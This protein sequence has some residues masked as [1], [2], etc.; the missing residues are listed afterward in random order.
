VAA[1]FGAGTRHVF[2]RLRA[3]V[4][5]ARPRDLVRAIVRTYDDNDLLTYAS[6]ISFQV[7]FALIPLLLFA[8]GL[9]GFLSLQELWRSDIA[10]EIQSRV[11]AAAFQ[12][13]S[14]TV[15]QVLGAKHLFWVTFGAVIAVWEISGAVRAVM[16][17]FNRIYGIDETRS[18]WRR[19]RVSLTLAAVS[20]VLLLLA[21]AVVRFGGLAVDALGAGGFVVDLAGFV[22]RWAV[23][24]ALMLVVVG[25]MV[26][27][28][29]NARRA[30][31]WVSF[32]ALLVVVGWAAMTAGFWWYVSNV[33]E[34]ESIFGS[35]ATVIVVMTYL[36]WS[37]IVFL[38]GVQLDALVEEGLREG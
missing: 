14:S 23:A 20:G 1:G 24:A 19:M 30:L 34:Y 10:P 5:C 9:L 22:V 21:A 31:H 28:A 8:L 17:V 37:T 7:F 18:F 2:A 16:G 15:D 13:I 32:G 29:P 11:S 6:A 25:V 33:A 35:L 27:F 36:Y 4:R 26:R 12:V 38:T 3:E